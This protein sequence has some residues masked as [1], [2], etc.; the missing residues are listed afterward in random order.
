MPRSVLSLLLLLAIGLGLFAGPHPCHA[1]QAR[2]EAAQKSCHMQMKT[3]GPA[4]PSLSAAGGH[5][6]CKTSHGSLCEN[7]C[8]MTAVSRAGRLVFRIAPV[9]RAVAETPCYELSLLAH[10]IDHIPL[11]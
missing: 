8:Q 7:V 9:A 3:A 1:R 5:D 2:P 11:A 6:C 10:G 4:G